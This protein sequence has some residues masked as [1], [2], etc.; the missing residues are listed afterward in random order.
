MSDNILD[1][2]DLRPE[3]QQ[4]RFEK[5]GPLYDMLDP[6]EMSLRDRAELFGLHRK[7]E[8]LNEKS[9]LTSN[10]RQALAQAIDEAARMVLPTMPADEL[11]ALPDIYKEAVVLGFMT[12]FGNTINKLAAVT[13]G[14]EMT[15][16]LNTIS[17]K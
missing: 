8:K 1:L 14:Q 5:D 4:V 17:G 2:T 13:G 11:K 10:E 9:N 3:R 16:A 7:M 15:E 6:T 12:A